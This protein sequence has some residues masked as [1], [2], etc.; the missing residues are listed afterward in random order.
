MSETPI[1]EITE[2]EAAQSQPHLIVNAGF[3][4][5]E[6]A[7]QLVVDDQTLTDPPGSPVEGERHIVATPATGLW[8]GREG[9][10][11]VLI[12]GGWEFLRP[13]IGWLAYVTGDAAFYRYAGGSPAGWTLFTAG[14]GGGGGSGVPVDASAGAVENNFNPAGWAGGLGVSQLRITP[15]GGGSSITG[16]DSSGV[17]DGEERTLMNESAADTITLPNN[18]GGSSAGNKFF[19]PGGFDVALEPRG[20]LRIIF[21]AAD[22]GWRF[23]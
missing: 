22:G 6:A 15:A 23:A 4:R 12:G 20:G 7:V 17:S 13:Q 8:L 19:G 18:A 16:L 5:L 2:M 14:G 9:D 3:R 10:V 21:H 11:A 1:L